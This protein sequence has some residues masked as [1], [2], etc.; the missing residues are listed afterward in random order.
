MIKTL[1]DAI[2]SAATD[3]ATRAL[4]MPH[5]NIP[6]LDPQQFAAKIKAETEVNAKIIRQA[7]IT[8]E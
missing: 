7:A 5:G 2:R 3:P 1:S 8:L 4:L 6:M